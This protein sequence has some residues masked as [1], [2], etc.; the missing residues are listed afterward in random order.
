[1]TS[2]RDELME[3]LY[4]SGRTLQQVGD[5]F[6]LTRERVRQVLAARGLNGNDGGQAVM[7]RA[8]AK[9]KRKRREEK[10]LK[11][12]GLPLFEYETL[13]DMGKRMMEDG[14]HRDR[15]PIGAYCRQRQNADQ[16]GYDWDLSLGEWW[17]IWEESGKWEKRGLRSEGYVLARIIPELPFRKYNVMVMKLEEV[18]TVQSEFRKHLFNV[19]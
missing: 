16:Q 19:A 17:E 2:N 1:M 11:E 7:A 8:R 10:C 4:R 9:A 18:R 3:A 15:T 13:L 12:K 14:L 5:E 6:D